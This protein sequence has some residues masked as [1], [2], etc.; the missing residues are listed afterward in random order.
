[1]NDSISVLIGEFPWPDAKEVTLVLS[2]PEAGIEPFT[3]RPMMAIEPGDN[4]KLKELEGLLT[5]DGIKF[6]YFTDVS[7]P[8]L[9][10][11]R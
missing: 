6:Q 8:E 11:P 1:M 7:R 4:D 5:L 3:A 9:V 10:C 2:K